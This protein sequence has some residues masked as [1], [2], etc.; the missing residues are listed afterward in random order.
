M[1]KDT[2]LQMK[3]EVIFQFSKKGEAYE[4]ILSAL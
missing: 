1:L 4:N 3:E 2:L